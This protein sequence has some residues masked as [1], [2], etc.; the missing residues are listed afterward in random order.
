MVQ[1]TALTKFNIFYCLCFD[2]SAKSMRHII[3]KKQIIS[4]KDKLPERSI[5][6]SFDGY[7]KEETYHLYNDIVKRSQVQEQD[8]P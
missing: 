8:Q 7:F 2:F 5:I 3:E 1:R 4:D 6:N